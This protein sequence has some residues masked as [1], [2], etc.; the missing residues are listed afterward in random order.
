MTTHN[1]ASNATRSAGHAS[2][3]VLTAAEA[4]AIVGGGFFG[5]LWDAAKN[6]YK[7]GKKTVRWMYEKARD[8]AEILTDRLPGPDRPGPFK[9]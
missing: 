2:M 5:D 1:H 8:A 9:F 7:A 3:E 4:D 6:V